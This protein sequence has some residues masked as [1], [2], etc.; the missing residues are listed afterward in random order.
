M[1]ENP[2]GMERRMVVQKLDVWRYARGDDGS[3][4]MKTAIEQMFVEIAPSSFVLDVTDENTEPTFASI[5]TTITKLQGT[6]LVGHFVSAA[7]ADSLMG[8]ILE[9]LS[10]VI[11]K[12]IPA[13]VSGEFEQQSENRIYYRC[14]LLP[15]S[16]A[17]EKINIV[18]GAVSFKTE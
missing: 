14:I 13:T 7:T 12:K 16:A 8:C 3:L 4:P 17:S 18:M 10:V 5:G 11:D 9:T 6:D 15:L 2:S 1:A